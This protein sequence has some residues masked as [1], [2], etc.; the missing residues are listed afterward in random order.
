VA[1]DDVI[2]VKVDLSE[3][4]WASVREALAEQ[5]KFLK[6]GMVLDPE[7]VVDRLKELA[8]EGFRVKLPAVL[9][10]EFRFPTVF[11]RMAQ[12]EGRPVAV[13]VRTQA[14]EVTPTAMWSR[15]AIGI[16]ADRPLR[17]AREAA[18]TQSAAIEEN[19]RADLAERERCRHEP[20]SLR[21]EAG[22]TGPLR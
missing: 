19:D 20:P 14:V 12:I 3:R 5:D 8:A 18:R 21:V 22:L 6:C 16:G 9:F 4:S 15:A 11:E 2:Q 10:R 13:G 17:T 7:K 1:P